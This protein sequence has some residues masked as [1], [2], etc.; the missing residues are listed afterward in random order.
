MNYEDI[1]DDDAAAAPEAQFPWP[2]AEGESIPGAFARTWRGAALEPRRFF[3]ALPET[4][5]LG[6]ALLYYLPLGILVAAGNFMWAAVGGGMGA[7]R[8]AVL[9]AETTFTPLVQFLLSPLILLLSLFLAAGVTHLLL[10]LLGGATRDFGFT[11]RLFAFAYSPQAVGVVPVVGTAIGFAWM[12]V[13]AIVGLREGHRTTT[14]R[15]AAAVL[16]PVMIGL[17]FVAAATF[18]A[19][20]GRLLAPDP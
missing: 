15:A 13:V 19:L 11:S 8:D 3:A 2:P 14:G 6:A 16:V 18:I 7:E 10:R 1:Y 17:V 12:V 20:T 5:S 9:G 4:G